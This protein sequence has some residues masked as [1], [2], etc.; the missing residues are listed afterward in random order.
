M[1]IPIDKHTGLTAKRLRRLLDYD[2]STGKF[3]WRV[4]PRNT[5]AAGDIAGHR[6][7][8]DG[9]V[10]ISI[11]GKR[12]LAHRL[13]W[14]W[15]TGAWP[16]DLIEHKKP[17]P[18]REQARQLARC[19]PQAKPIAHCGA[20]PRGL[21]K[22]P[23]FSRGGGDRGGNDIPEVRSRFRPNT[24]STHRPASQRYAAPGPSV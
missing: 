19:N 21:K 11:A 20:R 15:C 22:L 10:A 13:V 9:Y 23:P 1:S 3:R 8:S 5:V 16:A 14:L 2:R 18:R 24:Y 4:S 17:D 6:K 12:Y 7:K